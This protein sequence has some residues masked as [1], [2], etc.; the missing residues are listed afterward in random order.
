MA[1]WQRVNV[2]PLSVTLRESDSNSK[3]APDPLW[4]EM[5]VSER[6]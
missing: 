3:T 6:D 5:S 4:R 1:E 2:M